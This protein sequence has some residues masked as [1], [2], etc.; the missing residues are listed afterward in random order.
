MAK[1]EMKV[2]MIPQ[3]KSMSCWYASA[4]MVAA[5]FEGG[6]RLGLPKKWSEDQ[7]LT[8]QEMFKL[9]KVE[10]MIQL[11]SAEH[12]FTAESLIANLKYYGPLHCT[13]EWMAMKHAVVIT[14]C[15]TEGPDGGKVYFN[16]PLPE[17]HGITDEVTIKEFNEGRC[18]GFLFARDPDLRP[19]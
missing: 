16:D 3:R 2:P 5:Y 1:F 13:N 6:P 15:S 4:C 7:G 18:R 8:L 19:A 10:K 12:D 11:N 17:D 14:G 9:A